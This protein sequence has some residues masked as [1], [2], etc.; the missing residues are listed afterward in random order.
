MAVC[1]L[2]VCVLFFRAPVREGR[3]D[4]FVAVGVW[5]ARE[6]VFFMNLCEGQGEKN[7]FHIVIG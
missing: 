5:R 3:D 2:C 1:C 7:V 6:V 4:I